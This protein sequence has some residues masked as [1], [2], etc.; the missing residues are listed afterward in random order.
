MTFAHGATINSP[1]PST[2]EGE[3]GGDAYTDVPPIL[4]FPRAGGK[5]LSDTTPQS[6]PIFCGLI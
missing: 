3:G 5:G 2:G 6:V 1:A 4:T